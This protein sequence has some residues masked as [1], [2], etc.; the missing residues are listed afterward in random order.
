MNSYQENLLKEIREF[1]D[2]ATRM[3]SR[4]N[5]DHQRLRNAASA[6]E[7]ANNRTHQLIGSLESPT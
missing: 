3:L 4:S 6:L 7:Q 5:I 1:T 2:S